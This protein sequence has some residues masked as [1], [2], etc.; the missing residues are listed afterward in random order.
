MVRSRGTSP[1]GLVTSLLFRLHFHGTL[2]MTAP[3]I[4]GVRTVGVLGAG[5]LG[6]T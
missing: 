4:H 1:A 3:I 5:Q 6:P 2:R